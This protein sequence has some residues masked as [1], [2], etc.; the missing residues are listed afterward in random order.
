LD[1]VL[2]LAIAL[3]FA[4]GSFMVPWRTLAWIERWWAI[5]VWCDVV[6]IFSIPTVPA[7]SPWRPATDRVIGIAVGVCVLLMVA[8]A[9]LASRR[10]AEGRPIR[11]LLPVFAVGSVPLLLVGLT[12]LLWLL[13]SKH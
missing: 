9:V 8:G 3:I 10:S 13:A 5:L 2:I 12:S 1:V 7:T 11:H 4:V 6:A